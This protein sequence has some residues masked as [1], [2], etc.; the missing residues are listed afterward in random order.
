MGLKY[1]LLEE[2]TKDVNVRQ[3]TLMESPNV[4]KYKAG[5]FSDDFESEDSVP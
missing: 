5:N 2:I 4:M 1:N 3:K